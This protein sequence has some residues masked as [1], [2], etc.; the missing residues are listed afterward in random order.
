M[1]IE[2]L[3]TGAQEALGGLERIRAVTSYRAIV[4][5][6]HVPSGRVS[7]LTI[8]RAAGGRIRIDEERGKER[9]IRATCG[10][11]RS[12][13]RTRAK[14]LRDARLSPRNMLAHA[15][16]RRLALRN[17]P[18]PDGCH[19]VSAPDEL[20]LYFVDPV[21]LRCVR[22]IDLAGRC[23]YSYGDYRTVDGIVTPFL[24]RHADEETDKGSVDEYVDVVYDVALPDDL[25]A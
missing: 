22:M 19:V 20:A 13:E 8:W 7:T 10:A 21:A 25:F 18:A 4:R 11:H 9:K 23:R 12:D 15:G 1:T 5:R 16:E 6:T 3:I 17:H 14:M 24:E 2:E